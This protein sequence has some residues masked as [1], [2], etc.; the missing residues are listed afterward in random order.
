MYQPEPDRYLSAI[1]LLGDFNP[2]I[3]QPSWFRAEGLVSQKEVEIAEVKIIHRDVSVFT[4]DWLKIEVIRERFEVQT[5]QAPYNEPL[6]DLVIGTFSLLKH[7][8]LKMLGINNV[9][10]FKFDT[11]DKWQEAERKLIVE[12][13]WEKIIEKPGLKGLTIES[14]RPDDL[15]GCIRVIV[16]PSPKFRPGV[17]I[18]FNDH[19]EVSDEE[20]AAG[21]D[22]ITDILKSA[23]PES[24]KRSENIIYTLLERLK[25]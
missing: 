8:P 6:R 14:P 7:T 22:K 21:A 3:F 25:S 11:Q 2:S 4:L 18:S 16:E 19:Y 17:V 13:I 24:Q 10:H 20:K 12:G 23:W 9:M 5:T 15:K 1:V